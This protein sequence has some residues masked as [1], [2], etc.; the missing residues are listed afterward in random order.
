MSRYLVVYGTLRAGLTRWGLAASCAVALLGCSDDDGDDDGPVGP[1]GSEELPTQEALRAALV[2]A[3]GDPPAGN[4]G[5]SLNMWA[6]VVDRSGIVRAVA[7]TGDK[8]GDQWPG[9]RVISAQKANT[10]NSF[11]L[12]GLALST[13]NLFSP[14]QPGGSLFGLQ[15]SNPVNTDAAYGGNADDY[16]TP[17]DYMVGKRIG[18]VNVFGG[19]L[20]LYNSA[21]EVI[22]AVGVS[23]DTSCADHNIGWKLRDALVLDFVPGGV[24]S[25]GDDNIIYDI[26]V[27]G[28]S[29]GGFGHPECG[30]DATSVGNNLPATNPISN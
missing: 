22:G 6:T 19:G 9:S 25:T 15:E 20:A 11:S 18:G 16:G 21:G 30:V 28:V 7:Y 23:G 4:G 10:A 17:D 5:L 29:A 26:G 13:A 2:T 27:D 8:T 12:D 1:A 24:S 14:T 3:V